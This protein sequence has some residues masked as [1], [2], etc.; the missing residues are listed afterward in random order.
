MLTKLPNKLGKIQ[1][2]Y[3]NTWLIQE[4]TG[5]LLGEERVI[6]PTLTVM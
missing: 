6:C 3:S 5:L 4:I 2:V 1:Q